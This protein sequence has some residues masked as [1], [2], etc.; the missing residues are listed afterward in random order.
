MNI[1]KTTCLFISLM[2]LIMVMPTTITA[3]S[4]E[5]TIINDTEISK[6]NLNFIKKQ[7]LQA[8]DAWAYELEHTSGATF[9]YVDDNKTEK[10]FSIG[11]KTP[12]L[13]NNGANHVLEHSLLCGSEKYPSRDIQSYMRS[14]SVPTFMNAYTLDD[15]NMYTVASK[16]QQAFNNLLDVYVNAVFDPII[17]KDENIYKQQGIRKEY[18]DGKVQYNGVVYNEIRGRENHFDIIT[19]HINEAMFDALYGDSPYNMASGGTLKGLEELSYQ[20]ILSTHKKYYRP[21]NSIIYLSGSQDLDWTFKTLDGYL[22]QFNDSEDTVELVAN[23]EIALSL[24]KSSDLILYSKEQPK[25]SVS[26]GKL[27][28]GPKVKN[29]KE[30][31]A[32]KLLADYLYQSFST[33][34]S[35]AKVISSESGGIESVGFVAMNVMSK[36][37][38]QMKYEKMIHS[39][40]DSPWDYKAWN[41]CIDQN[42]RS[43]QYYPGYSVPMNILIG[44]TYAD[45]PLAFLDKTAMNDF[46][47]QPKNEAYLKKVLKKYFID[48]PYQVTVEVQNGSS[49]ESE[50]PQKQYSNA[51]IQEIKKQTQQF[52]N[53]G[54]TPES[55]DVL[56]KRPV[57]K[58]ED[59]SDAKLNFTTKTENIAGTDFL[60]TITNEKTSIDL[61]F[62]FDLSSLDNTQLLDV[63][64]LTDLYNQY[65]VEEDIT[66]ISFG[67]N[68][69][70]DFYDNTKYSS[71]LSIKITAKN[72]EIAE[73]VKTVCSILQN[74][75]V[76]SKKSVGSNIETI[77]ANVKEYT[78][79]NMSMFEYAAMQTSAANRFNMIANGI[80]GYGTVEYSEY[81]QTIL[82]GKNS[83]DMVE[84]NLI[85]IRDIVFNKNQ[86]SVGITCKEVEQT[87]VSKH[88]K[89][90][91]EILSTKKYDSTIV[92]LPKAYSSLAII[93]LSAK[94]NVAK[95]LCLSGNVGRDVNPSKSNVFMNYMHSKYF[96]PKAR[97]MGAYGFDTFTD[98]DGS[99]IITMT[100]VPDV[101]KTVELI[102]SADDFLK[103]DSVHQEELNSIIIASV[104]K[105]D[106]IYDSTNENTIGIALEM[107]LR[108][109]NEN[110]I[111]K[112][113]T[114]MLNT[115]AKDIQDISKVLSPHLAENL[116]LK[117]NQYLVD[118]SEMKF[119]KILY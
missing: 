69:Y 18:A 86:L 23:S 67:M 65:I 14:T 36:E 83:I 25:E 24:P 88:A 105:W 92:Q 43:E 63:K 29:I 90:I 22:T 104:N 81:L 44:F 55:N 49:S 107:K 119:D 80:S 35:D 48:T 7:Y 40:F 77:S 41:Q 84:N 15:F 2:L 78:G 68:A 8:S 57:L 75:A 76:L 37:Q 112:Y 99:Y 19:N 94:E 91:I 103:N 100:K 5:N 98:T 16:N 116:F 108:N 32:F 59:F 33:E 38:F 109:F 9:I 87:T 70:N 82:A 85:K 28:S 34:F 13:N 114:D 31:S 118:K 52:E 3:K 21:S 64:L 27:I 115:T 74:K 39:L 30:Q 17:L 1:K 58:L 79:S 97:N 62:A 66:G 6:Y 11:F 110:D 53:W 96:Y 56:K 10:V 4:L 93:D 72:D 106:E 46:F 12:P 20:E 60:Y 101:N 113:R 45:D 89:T 71:I 95:E 42:T 117:A 54:N 111:L 73:K 26:I 50:E 47:K 102:K 51:Q 61:A